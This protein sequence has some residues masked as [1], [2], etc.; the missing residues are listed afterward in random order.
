M[1]NKLEINQVF[2]YYLKIEPRVLYVVWI[3][4]VWSK[5]RDINNAFN[6]RINSFAWTTMAKKKLI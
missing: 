2:E 5:E 6:G 1:L 3:L 4:R